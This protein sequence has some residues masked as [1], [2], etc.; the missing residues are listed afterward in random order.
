M[1]RQFDVA[2]MH[3]FFVDRL[4]QAG[5]L[6]R[7]FSAIREKAH[8][9]GGGI[10][11]VRQSQVKG[12]NAVN[13]AHALATLGRKTLLITHT[14]EQ[15]RSLLLHPFRGL[16]AEVRTK[17]LPPGLTVA[18]EGRV[19]VMLGHAGGAGEFSPSL[20]DEEDWAA[21]RG[22]SVVCSV[23]WSANMHGTELLGALRSRLGA[24]KTIFLDPADVRD[25]AAQFRQFLRLTKRSGLVN[26]YSLNEYEAG[27]TAA[28]LGLKARGP[29][30]VCRAIARELGAR[31]D[32]H[33]ERCSYS[34]EGGEVHS[35]RVKWV[36]PRRLTG[37]GD[38][39]AAAAIHGKLAGMAD[40]RR[41]RF[42]NT[43]ARLYLTAD[44]PVPPTEAEVLAAV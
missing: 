19:N 7:T 22:S 10:H 6:E 17:P 14:D 2:V 39:W 11:G 38:V 32:L 8:S 42:A 26:W 28:L 25:R 34:S 13:L 16:P 33:T 37:A 9:G 43:A 44:E 4:V 24:G 31:V 12:G 23:N 35:S 41:L 15:H 30:T 36:K 40:E 5:D 1:A 29:A 27:A 20:L 3:D 18:M 21:L